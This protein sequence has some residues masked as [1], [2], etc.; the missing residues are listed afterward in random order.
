MSD[1]VF[2]TDGDTFV[3][4][5]VSQATWYEGVL[6]GGPVAALFAREFERLDSA[7]P[8]QVARMTID[9]IRPVPT[10]PLRVHTTVTREGRRI[11]TASAWMTAGDTEVARA[12]MVRIRSDDVAVPEHPRRDAPPGPDGLPIYRM[13][14]HDEGEWFHTR[15][16]EMRFAEG[17]FAEP[18]PVVVWMR[19]LCPVV[20]GEDASPLQRTAAVADFP[21]GVSR[22]LPEGWLY[23]NPDLTIHAERYP[24]GEWVALRARTDATGGIGLAQ[25]ELFDRGGSFGHSLQSLVVEDRR[26]ASAPR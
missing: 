25:A 26:G 12:S 18:G 16:V 2:V 14:D 5:Q 9:L 20:A 15:G 17:S 4:Q 13:P 21:N 1:A 11:Q 10:E 7:V 3:P 23:I 8:M 22:F 6:H 19:L 24:E